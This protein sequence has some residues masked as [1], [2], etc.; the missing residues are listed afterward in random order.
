M[1]SPCPDEFISF[2]HRLADASGAVIRPHFRANVAIE[3]KPDH[4]PVTVADKAAE[5]A[6]RTLLERHYPAHAILGEEFGA[7][8]VERSARRGR[9][10]EVLCF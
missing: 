3:N 4:S 2:A 8:S 6:I 1:A 7:Q 5:Q 9:A 10:E